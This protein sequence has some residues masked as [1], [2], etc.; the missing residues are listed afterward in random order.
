MPDGEC[1]V[2]HSAVCLT[3]RKS[4]EVPTAETVHQ[5]S[6]QAAHPTGSAAA[7]WPGLPPQSCRVASPLVLLVVVQATLNCGTVKGI[8]LRA[9]LRL[10]IAVTAINDVLGVKA[11]VVADVFTQFVIDRFC[12]HSFKV[13]IVQQ[14]FR[15]LSHHHV[16]SALGSGYGKY[17]TAQE[18]D[19]GIYLKTKKRTTEISTYK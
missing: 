6:G 15:H 7:G 13:F 19:D 5:T 4:S 12:G 2:S 3:G 11:Q 1:P 10:P 14:A 17:E 18:E 16:E 8:D 9:V